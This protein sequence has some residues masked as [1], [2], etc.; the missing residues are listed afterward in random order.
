MARHRPR[1]GVVGGE[2]TVQVA[3]IEAEQGLE[4]TGPPSRLAAGSRLSF[5]PSSA[6]VRGMSCISPWAPFLDTARGAKPDSTDTTA[7]TRSGSRP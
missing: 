4:V 2:G 5:T 1:S 3:P 6:A 7:R